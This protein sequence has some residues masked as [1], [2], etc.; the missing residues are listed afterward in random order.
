MPVLPISLIKSAD[1]TGSNLTRWK[2]AVDFQPPSTKLGD[3]TGRYLR[4]G[5]REH[6]MGAIMN[7]KSALLYQSSA[8]RYPS[9]RSTRTGQ[10]AGQVDSPASNMPPTQA[11]YS[12]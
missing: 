7:G 12:V 1:L 4:Y 11:T 6:G 9:A 10:Q 3:Y 5:V 8:D 2:D